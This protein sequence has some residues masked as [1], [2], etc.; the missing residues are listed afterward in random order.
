MEKQNYKSPTVQI[1]DFSEQ[2]QT[3]EA[4]A[5]QPYVDGT[6]VLVSWLIG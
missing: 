5:S 6:S 4:N 2:V 1:I 3:L